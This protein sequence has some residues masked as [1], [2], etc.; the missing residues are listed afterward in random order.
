MIFIVD[1]FRS[2]F[3]DIMQL[4]EV[5]ANYV[6]IYDQM[7]KDRDSS[8]K[9]IFM[10]SDATVLELQGVIGHKVMWWIM[11]NLDK[12]STVELCKQLN[13]PIDIDVIWNLTGSNPREIVTLHTISWNIETYVND[14]IKRMKEIIEIYFREFTSRGWSSEKI[15]DILHDG[16][17][18][19]V[20]EIDKI[21]FN[22]LSDYLLKKNIIMNVD[23]RFWKLSSLSKESW[24]G[25]DYAFQIPI[26]YWILKT[27][28]EKGIDI[29]TQN[30]LEM[31]KKC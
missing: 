11:W 13:C 14:K 3:K 31:L 21:G 24:I 7:F 9:E 28:Y 26:C 4:L 12:E 2:V 27:M 25:N 15:W 17:Y 20:Y 23:V 1:E 18:K 10:T 5:E 29:T 22:I 19:A 16:I 8:F 6:R 30:V